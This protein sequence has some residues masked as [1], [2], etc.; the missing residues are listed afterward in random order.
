MYMYI[1]AFQFTRLVFRTHHYADLMTAGNVHYLPLGA[2]SLMTDLLVDNLHFSQR[3]FPKTIIADVTQKFHDRRW[4]CS[5]AG[6]MKYANRGHTFESSRVEMLQV[7]QDVPGCVFFPTD[8]VSVTA[9]LSQYE[10]LQLAGST[11]FSLC[12]RGVG[13]E[14]NR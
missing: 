8:D 4:I 13:P 3:R 12:P 1:Y 9:P 2:G 5:F 11:V 14:T 10:Y 6:S 7:L